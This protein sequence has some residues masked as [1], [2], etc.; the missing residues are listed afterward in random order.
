MASNVDHL[1]TEEM[2]GTTDAADSQTSQTKDVDDVSLEEERRRKRQ[3][4]LLDRMPRYRVLCKPKPFPYYAIGHDQGL[5]SLSGILVRP[6]TMANFLVGPAYLRH[7]AG[8]QQMNLEDLTTEEKGAAEL[9]LRRVWRLPQ[10]L[11]DT[12]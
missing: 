4:E 8:S 10:C 2:N 9:L 1:Q 3:L 6:R 5:S 11:H 7:D 12:V